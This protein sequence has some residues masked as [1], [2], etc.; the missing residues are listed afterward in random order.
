MP[1]Q[2]FSEQTAPSKHTLYVLVRK[3]ISLAQQLV[4]TG[5]AAAEAGKQFYRQAHGIA[6]L[7]VL[8]VPDKAA[9]LKAHKHLEGK[10]L[11][12]ALFF[13]PDFNIGHSA[14]ATE[15]LPTEQRKHLMSWPLW[16]PSAE[17]LA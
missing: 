5:H 1:N 2:D 17:E 14:L 11:R 3:D 13:E 4:Q 15:P 16:K 10:G 8:S 9:L 6:S 12:T 7:I